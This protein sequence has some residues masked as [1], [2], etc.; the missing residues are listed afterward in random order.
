MVEDAGKEKKPHAGILQTGFHRVF[1]TTLSD[2]HQY[3]H[4]T[5]EETEAQG[6]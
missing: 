4:F 6:V 1:E 3:P 2:R 5:D